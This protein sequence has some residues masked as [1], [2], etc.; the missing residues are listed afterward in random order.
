MSDE[1]IFNKYY[2]LG[3][4]EIINHYKV[5]FLCSRKVPA[6]KILNIYD[7]AIEQREKGVCVVSGFHSKIE[8]DVFHYLSKGKQPIILVLAR[9]MFL[10]LPGELRKLVADNK[11]LIITE[12]EKSIK[13]VNARTAFKRNELI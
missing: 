6:E 3:N 1:K 10:R 8:K 9:G 2:Y 4:R 13:R 11:L 7:W 5:G 12:F